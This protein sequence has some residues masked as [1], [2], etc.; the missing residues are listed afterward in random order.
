MRRRLWCRA[1]PWLSSAASVALTGCASAPPP[2]APSAPPP[3]IAAPVEAP[4]DLS[5]VPEPTTLVTV[6]RWKNVASTLGALDKMTNLASRTQQELE[7]MLGGAEVVKAL[8]LD[9]NVDVAALLDTG[10]SSPTPQLAAAFSM[11]LRSID[12]ARAAAERQG[13]TVRQ[14]RPGA[15]RLARRRGQRGTVC[16]IATSKGDAPARLVCAR[17]E[18]DLDALTPFL[19]RTMPEQTFGKGDVS[20]RVRVAP[21]RETYNRFLDTTGRLAMPALSFYMADRF[22]ISDPI[23]GET[24]SDLAAETSDILNDVDELA[25]DAMIEP[26]GSSARAVGSVRYRGKKSWT[27]RALT[28]KN[29]QS[30]P[31]PPIF[32]HAPKDSDSVSYS[33]GSDR[34]LARA[35]LKRLGAIASA[36]THS[37]LSEPDRRALERALANLPVSDTT[38]VTASGH[39]DPPK[40]AKAALN[41]P[42]ERV[43]A[44]RDAFAQSVGWML[45]GVDGPHVAIKDWLRDL[46]I[47]ANGRGV[48]EL[49][50]KGPEELKRFKPAFKSV[51]PPAGLPTGASAFELSANLDSDMLDRAAGTAPPAAPAKK[52]PAAAKAR[53]SVLIVVMPDGIDRTWVGVA[54]DPAL[55]KKRLLSVRANAPAENKLSAREGLE[56]LREEKHLSA[57]FSS[58][59]GVSSSLRGSGLV[60]KLMLEMASL[61]DVDATLRALPNQ[62]QTPVFFVGDGSAGGA[63][64]NSIELR[65]RRETIEDTIAF[66]FALG[67]NAQ[68]PAPGPV[69]PR[70]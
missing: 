8:K 25:F 7:R 45:V 57:S 47:L 60:A 10:G 36:L 3:V 54:S 48:R 69:I 20:V 40:P 63:P 42:A 65:V 35:P 58:L 51:P 22:G 33:R 39:L 1:L 11:P 16:D 9:G 17:R 32:W 62:G 18:R 23:I 46:S 56:S 53:L 6:A 55:L 67:A 38:S 68:L 64:T 37:L 70:P 31:P 27:A 52:A 24:V 15:W 21:L 43:G 49:L 50:E 41:T 44:A 29:D 12:E 26:D 59:A 19:A 34:E 14:L 4:V 13:A 61:G 30:G 28:H 5:P 2:P 66:L